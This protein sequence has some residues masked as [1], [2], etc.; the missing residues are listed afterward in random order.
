MET[1]ELYK[2]ELLDHYRRPRNRGDLSDTDVVSRGSNPRCGDDLEIGIRCNGDLLQ[3]VKFRGRSCAI[4]IASASML[5]EAVTNKSRNTVKKLYNDMTA[6]FNSG[7]V[8]SDPP[9]SLQALSA[10]RGYP[11]RKRCV[12]LAWEALNDALADQ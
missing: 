9:A 3:K 7:D 10:V 8:P 4:C 6:W 11:A 1:T 12:L 5:A 2:N